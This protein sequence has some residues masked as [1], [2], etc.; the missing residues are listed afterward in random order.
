[1]QFTLGRSGFPPMA[2]RA[3]I[4][5]MQAEAQVFHR[6]TGTKSTP[7]RGSRGTSQGD[8]L[9]P[10]VFAL[11]MVPTNE[12]IRRNTAGA[13]TAPLVPGTTI[14]QSEPQS[15]YADDTV[16]PG[17]SKDS[18]VR[19]IGTASLAYCESGHELGIRPVR[20]G[21]T[22][23]TAVLPTG[24]ARESFQFTD[25][26]VQNGT[27]V[28]VSV[29]EAREV[30]TSLYPD[31][32]ASAP[33]PTPAVNRYTYLGYVLSTRRTLV[34]SLRP[35]GTEEIQELHLLD[36]LPYVMRQVGRA[37]KDIKD[38]LTAAINSA[39]SIR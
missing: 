15:H 3:L 38:L 12:F 22:S 19:M 37:K 14:G 10:D 31:T 36:P 11:S 24:Q 9:S 33:A 16:N 27:A 1:M 7:F 39:W 21:T 29:D 18:A 13:E 26:E 30:A 20:N 8:P 25:E 5:R 28:A 2:V 23:K 34:K 4:S 6:R 32:T 35:D 17:L